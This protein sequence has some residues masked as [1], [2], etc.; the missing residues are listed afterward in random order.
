MLTISETIKIVSWSYLTCKIGD[1]GPYLVANY[2]ILISLM[3]PDTHGCVGA[4]RGGGGKRL[5]P[6]AD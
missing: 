4:G 6:R 2:R 5:A 1:F 3:D